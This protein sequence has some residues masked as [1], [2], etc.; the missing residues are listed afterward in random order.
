ML[1][2]S[3]IGLETDV[4]PQ[5]IFW[6]PLLY[7]APTIRQTEDNLDRFRVVSFTV[8]NDLTFDLRNY[9]GHPERCKI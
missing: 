4:A 5:A 6:R 9:R 1:R 3:K 8:D 2:I 7:F